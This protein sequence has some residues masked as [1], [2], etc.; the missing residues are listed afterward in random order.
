MAGAAY[1][2]HLRHEVASARITNEMLRQTNQANVAAIAAY[3]AQAVR[4]NSALDTLGA[5]TLA[6]SHALNIIDDHIAAQPPAADA[7]VAPVL[8]QALSEIAKLQGGAK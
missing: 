5:Q 4:W 6:S 7:P 1:V 2:G 3:Q 8:A